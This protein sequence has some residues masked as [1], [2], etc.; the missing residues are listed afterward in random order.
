[1]SAGRGG[2]DAR[3]ARIRLRRRM[4]AQG[5][6]EGGDG[7]GGG[8]GGERQGRREDGQRC[9]VADGLE[10]SAVRAPHERVE[11]RVE[12]RGPK[13]LEWEVRSVGGGISRIL[14]GVLM[15][16][17]VGVC[18]H[19][20][21]RA[22]RPPDPTRASRAR[23]QIGSGERSGAASPSRRYHTA[24]S[25]RLVL[26]SPPPL[27]VVLALVDWDGARDWDGDGEEERVAAP[28]TDDRSAVLPL[29]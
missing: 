28:V 11:V 27:L 12:G 21:R 17:G 13:K 9:Q 25:R 4:S 18:L 24:L 15:M 2:R 1:M 23:S 7:R 19:R 29:R 6:V 3:V 10:A 8:G 5:G 14:I 20:V 16:G 26:L 22:P